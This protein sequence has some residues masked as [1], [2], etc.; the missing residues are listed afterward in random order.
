MIPLL[1][2]LKKKNK[3]EN[4]SQIIENLTNQLRK[5]KCTKLFCDDCLYNIPIHKSISDIFDSCYFTSCKECN[6]CLVGNNITLQDWCVNCVPVMRR[7]KITFLLCNKFM[8]PKLKL[9]KPILNIIL[10]KQF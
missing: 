5:C 2:L 4:E 10:N 3:M 1:K 7:C 9:P 6:C 8:P